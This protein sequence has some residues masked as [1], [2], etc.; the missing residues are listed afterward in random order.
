M[1]LHDLIHPCRTSRHRGL[2]LRRRTHT[3]LT[4]GSLTI[5]LLLLLGCSSVP[6][7]P[8]GQAFP[9][10]PAPDYSTPAHWAALPT[11]DDEADRTPGTRFRD[12][13]ATA[14]ADVFFIHPTVYSDTRKGDRLWNANLA[15]TKLNAS[16]DESTIRNQAT[17]FNAAGRVYAPRY[18][19]ANLAVFYDA[20][21]SVKQQ[22]L[23]TAYT[24]VLAAFDYYLTNYHD[25]RPI[26]IA[27]HSQGTLHAKRL[28]KDRFAGTLHERLV[29]AYLVGM[30]IRTDEFANIPV[31]ADSTQTGCFV[32]WRTYREDFE[33]R[34]SQDEPGVA[35]VNPLTWSTSTA[36]A[37][38]ALNLGTVLYNFDADPKPGLVGA[39][40]RGAALYTNKPKFFGSVFFRTKN[41]HIA[42][43]NFFWVNVRNNARTRVQSFR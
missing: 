4:F 15:D 5:L 27:A 21:R 31:C 10:P 12:E 20:G 33:L 11:V 25:G 41:Y 36:P 40:I 39:E 37:S 35:V 26:I 24:D 32:S 9:V 23:D 34:P 29:A 18:R 28:L 14:A 13:Q 38:P 22:A 19:Q 17:V 43:Y 6:N 30:P 3:T 42:D 16:V 8:V 2:P 7:L 1:T